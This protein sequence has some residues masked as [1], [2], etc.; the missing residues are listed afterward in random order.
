MLK[1]MGLTEEQIDTIIEA[2]TDTVNA[3][4]DER[5]KYKDDAE[6]LPGVQKELEDLKKKAGEGFE[7]K[8]NDLQKEYEDYKKEQQDKANRAAVSDAYKEMLKEAG[9]SEKRIPAVMRVADLSGVKLDKDGNIKDKDKLVESVKEEWSD[10]I[11]A[12]GA[13]GADTKTPP[14]N[15]GGT[16]TKDDILKIKDAGER[17]QKIAENHELFGF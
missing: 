14:D 8:Y 10:F 11:Q 4:K 5:D 7:Q 1:G 15:N 17:Q 6:K 13:K 2:H 16:L 9:V 12:K 3:L